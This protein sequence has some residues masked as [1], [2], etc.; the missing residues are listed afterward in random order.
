MAAV[1]RSLLQTLHLPDYAAQAVAARGCNGCLAEVLAALWV[2]EHRKGTDD[3]SRAIEFLLALTPETVLTIAL[4]ADSG[5]ET[6]RLI[7]CCDTEEHDIAEFV[8]EVLI[9]VNRLKWLFL[10]GHCRRE[11]YTAHCLDA[12]KRNRSVS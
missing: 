12:L 7:R 5:D 2:T 4:V 8:M 9:Y 1:S 6:L 10:D 3:E 11:G